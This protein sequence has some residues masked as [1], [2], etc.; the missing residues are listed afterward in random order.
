MNIVSRKIRKLDKFSRVNIREY[1]WN[2]ID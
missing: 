2:Y 1:S